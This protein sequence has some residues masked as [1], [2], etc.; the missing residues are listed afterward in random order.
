MIDLKIIVF[1]DTIHIVSISHLFKS[2]SPK[3][4]QLR[5]DQVF[6]D[7]YCIFLGKIGIEIVI[8]YV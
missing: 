8:S 7:R 4:K 2:Y 3:S 6:I 5:N 1:L